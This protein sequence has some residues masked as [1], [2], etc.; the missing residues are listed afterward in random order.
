MNIACFV[1]FVNLFLRFF[2]SGHHPLP[3][4]HARAVKT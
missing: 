1:F 4:L 2:S 3:K